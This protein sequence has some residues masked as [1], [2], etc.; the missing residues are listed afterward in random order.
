MNSPGEGNTLQETSVETPRISIVDDDESVRE[1]IRSLL[2]SVGLRADVFAS[3]E[4][5]LSS[6]ALNDTACLILDLRMPGMSGLEL[7]ARLKAAGYKIPLI[8]I[9]AH[10]SDREARARALQ[11]GAVDFLF[12]PFKEEVLLEHVYAAIKAGGGEAGV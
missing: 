4:E 10:A 9:T 1:A 7:Q 5:F 6:A 2:R 3:A 8:F 12:K 11:A